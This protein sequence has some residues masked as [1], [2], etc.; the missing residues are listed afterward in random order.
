MEPQ[1]TILHGKSTGNRE[2]SSSRTGRRRMRALILLCIFFVII[3]SEGTAAMAGENAGNRTVKAG[4]FHFDGYHMKDEEGKL[5]GYGIDFLNLAA[6]YSHLN[7]EYVE[8]DKSWNDMLTMLEEGEID[9]VT[10]GRKTEEWE[11]KYAFSLPIGRSSTILS[12][13]AD[14]PRLHSGDYTTYDGMV[15]GVVEG[16]SQKQSLE[17]FAEEHGFTYRI[18]EYNSADELTEALQNNE[19]DAILSTSLRKTK[20]EKTRIP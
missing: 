6:E 19:I 2:V 5:T 7:F 15:I 18:I 3:I 10:S 1:N 12:I 8:Y 20:N 4:I 17:E 14:N 13:Q 16:R 11:E 9:I